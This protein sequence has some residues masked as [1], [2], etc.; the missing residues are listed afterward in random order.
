MNRKRIQKLE[1]LAYHTLRKHDINV[2]NPNIFEL[3]KK[4]NIPTLTMDKMPSSTRLLLEEGSKIGISA[5]SLN[6]AGIPKIYYNPEH[7]NVQRLIA[8]ELSH[9]ILNHKADDD[10]EE[11]EADAL[12]H[13][14]MYPKNQRRKKI[15]LSMAAF[16]VLFLFLVFYAI[17]YHTKPEIENQ[18]YITS[19]GDKYHVNRICAGE[20]ATPVSFETAKDLQKTPCLQCTGAD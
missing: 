6:S 8:H 20:N 13:M 3:A 9:I 2:E 5:I 12:A 11:K 17:G 10:T 14:L 18:V 7:K 16:V 19:S 1:K 4:L 15:S